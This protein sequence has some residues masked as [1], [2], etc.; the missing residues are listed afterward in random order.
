MYEFGEQ[1]LVEVVEP[2]RVIV[3]CGCV[4]GV[5]CGSIDETVFYDVEL[6][7]GSVINVPEQFVKKEVMTDQLLIFRN[8]IERLL[9]ND[10]IPIEAATKAVKY[11][12]G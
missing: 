1:V 11:W 3:Y 8:S 5:R 6:N 4:V 2:S 12:N 9:D 10:N 7:D